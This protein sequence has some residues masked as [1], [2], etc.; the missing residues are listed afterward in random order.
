MP[1]TRK[2]GRWQ[3]RRLEPPKT[4][5]TLTTVSNKRS[6]KHIHLIYWKTVYWKTVVH[7][8]IQEFFLKW[9]C[10]GISGVSD[11]CGSWKLFLQKEKQ[12]EILFLTLIVLS[13]RKELRSYL[14]LKCFWQKRM[15]IKL[16]YKLGNRK[17]FLHLH[18]LT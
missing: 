2:V 9:I 4:S 12:I 18:S 1:A 6:L 5:V 16:P 10:Q 8:S 17:Q 11:K 7:T 15:K 14:G 3:G 13:L